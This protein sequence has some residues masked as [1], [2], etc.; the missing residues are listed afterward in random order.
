MYINYK[1]NIGIVIKQPMKFDMPLNKQNQTKS[2]IYYRKYD[3][4][5]IYSKN[6]TSVRITRMLSVISKQ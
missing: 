6:K 2:D 5:R 3:K 4:C 1:H